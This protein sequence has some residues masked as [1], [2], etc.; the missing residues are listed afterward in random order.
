MCVVEVGIC[1]DVSSPCHSRLVS[2]HLCFLL[3]V[4][5]FSGGL[6]VMNHICRHDM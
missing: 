4:F 6:L 5:I 3:A 1:W 2:S